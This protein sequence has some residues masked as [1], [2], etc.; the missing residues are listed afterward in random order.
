MDLDGWWLFKSWSSSS[1]SDIRP[2]P[3]CTFLY[4]PFHKMGICI[5]VVDCV[6]IVII[7][8]ILVVVVIIMVFVLPLAPV[9]ARASAPAPA[10][11]RTWDKGQTLDTG[12]QR[13]DPR[14]VT[15]ATGNETRLT[16]SP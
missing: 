5:I 15:W 12:P 9:H 1:G 13:A 11:C 6:V 2:M 10:G 7:V 14:H 3:G 16:L 8:A 4:L